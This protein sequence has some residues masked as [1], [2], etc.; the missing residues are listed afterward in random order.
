MWMG[1]A[2]NAGI[3]AAL[4]SAPV[5][6]C[7]IASMRSECALSLGANVHCSSSTSG[8]RPAL[9]AL[10]GARL[11]ADRAAASRPAMAHGRQ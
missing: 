10:R 2:G 1:C 6:A 11:G 5:A 8:A 3:S 7:R 9:A 4:R